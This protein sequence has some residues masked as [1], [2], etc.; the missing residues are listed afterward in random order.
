MPMSP[1]SQ[2]TESKSQPARTEAPGVTKASTNYESPSIGECHDPEV[3][4]LMPCLNE[5]ETLEACIRKAQGFLDANQVRGEIVVSDSGSNDGSQEIARRCGARVVEVPSRG[6]G[7]ALIYGSSAA[8][9][10]S[11]S[12]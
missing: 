7:A 9:D 3:T 12:R 6:Y 5:S 10:F 1:V 8:T 11:H 4:I 2:I